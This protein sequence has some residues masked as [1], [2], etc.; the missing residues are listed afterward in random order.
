MSRAAA[1]SGTRP[2]RSSGALDLAGH[3]HHVVEPCRHRQ[4]RGQVGA[5]SGGQAHGADPERLGPGLFQT[6]ASGVAEHFHG[7]ELVEDPQ[8]VDGQAAAGR[9]EGPAE[10]RGGRVE[11]AEAGARS[12]RF[13]R[14][15][16][17]VRPTGLGGEA[18]RGGG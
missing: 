17:Q 13:Q 15:A 4:Q 10:G 18:D 14:L 12:Q 3:L 16:G 11:I 5:D 6:V 2:S 9:V 7:P 1:W 8:P